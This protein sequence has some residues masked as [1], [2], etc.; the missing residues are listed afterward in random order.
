MDT[1]IFREG[2]P[3]E[4]FYLITSGRVRRITRKAPA[5]FENFV[6]PEEEL[7][8]GDYFGTSAIL[9]S[10]E[11]KRHSTML[12]VTDVRV[13]R[14]GRDEFEAG[15][16]LNEGRSFSGGPS[17]RS[18]SEPHRQSSY[19]GARW[20]SSAKPTTLV[21]SASSAGALHAASL[22]AAALMHRDME[23]TPSGSRMPPRSKTANS[24][25]RSAKR[26]LRFIKMMS[27]N[28][29]RRCA[30]GWCRPTNAAPR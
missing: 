8:A 4:Y 27:N 20:S 21:G 3:S 13:V 5:R 22:P 28:E 1:V 23:H 26:S 19:D 6:A 15:Q 18:S 29:Q 2:D 11:R 7:G 9:G 24:A 25:S 30:Q 16:G 17:R 14:L 12:A 10:G